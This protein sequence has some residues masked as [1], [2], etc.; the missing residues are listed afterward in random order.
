ML[1]SCIQSHNTH[2]LRAYHDDPSMLPVITV[3][4]NDSAVDMCRIGRKL[5]KL[6]PSEHPFEATTRGECIRSNLH[7]GVQS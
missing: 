6:H 5:A 7:S 1:S 4:T 2:A 3:M